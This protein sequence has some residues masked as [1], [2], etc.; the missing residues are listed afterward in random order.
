MAL[1]P[2]AA[3]VQIITAQLPEARALERLT[4]APRP[5]ARVIT[6]ELLSDPDRHR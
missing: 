5:L 1:A 6:W 2:E 4:R 3:W